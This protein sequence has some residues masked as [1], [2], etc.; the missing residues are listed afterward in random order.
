M[1][2]KNLVGKVAI[3]T[4]ATQGIGKAIAIELANKGAKIV[5]NGVNEKK[6]EKVVREINKSTQTAL[7]IQADVS[8]GNEVEKMVSRVISRWGK[9]D[10]L[11]NN[12]GISPK[13]SGGMK[14]PIREIQEAEWE[15]VM[16]VNLKGVFNCSKAVMDFMSRQKAGKI[17][18]IASI[19]G[20]K[21]GNLTIS[22]AH[23][24]ASK[25]AVISFT[26]SLAGELAHC[27]INVNAVAP[28]RVETEMTKRGQP[29]MNEAFKSRIPWRR[30]GKPQEI[31]KVVAF[32]VS[33]EADYITGETFIIDGGAS[34]C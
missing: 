10:I 24:A 7:F 32:L 30:F 19:A 13:K 20:I 22:G 29:E 21:S 3:V 5:I 15:R 18:N 34:L 8:N 33:E 1:A 9:I 28:G 12:A 11:V 26:K 23:Y 16:D 31:A 25:A 2:L 6:G 27:R 4:G 17:I 14:I